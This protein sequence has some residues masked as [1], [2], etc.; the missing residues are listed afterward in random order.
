MLNAKCQ[1]STSVISKL[2]IKWLALKKSFSKKGNRT[3]VSKRN[4][5]ISLTIGK[6]LIIERFGTLRKCQVVGVRRGVA[7]WKC[8][9]KGWHSVYDEYVPIENIKCQRS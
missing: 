4:V 2:R 9:Y 3:E 7:S 1:S 5:G 6:T 8:T